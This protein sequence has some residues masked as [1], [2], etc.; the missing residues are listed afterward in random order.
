MY[1]EG[2]DPFSGP[3]PIASRYSIAPDKLGEAAASYRHDPAAAKKLMTEAGYPNGFKTKL[4]T[5]TGYGPEY[6][7]RSELLKDMLSKIGIDAAI[8]S[9]EYPVWIASTY[10]GSFDGVVHI[11][12]WTLGDEDEWLATY[13]PGDT[14]NQIHL[15]DPKLTDVVRM[16]REAPNDVA[17]AKLI[18]QFVRTFHEQMFRV[19]LPQPVLLTVIS[20]RVKGY[21]PA[22]RG[23]SYPTMLGNVWLE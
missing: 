17:R 5:T 18:G 8:V 1:P 4:Y 22:V 13:T 16:S 15:D 10:K 12:A 14:R 6:V 11:P 2:A 7:S 3:I 9:Q 23:Y 20:S 19:Y 21:V